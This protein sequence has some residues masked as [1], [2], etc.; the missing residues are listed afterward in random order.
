MHEITLTEE[1]H[2]ELARIRDSDPKPYRRERAAALL[3]VASGVPAAAVARD[4]LLRKRKAD[5]LYSWIRAF[6]TNG[7]EGLGIQP[8]RGRKRSN[9]H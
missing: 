8:G 5:T 1:Q 4:G 3:K 9:S 7:V 6:E 2:R